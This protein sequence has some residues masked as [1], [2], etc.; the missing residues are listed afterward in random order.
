MSVG[1]GNEPRACKWATSPERERVGRRGT[2]RLGKTGPPSGSVRDGAPVANGPA[3]LRSGFVTL[4]V[5]CVGYHD[6]DVSA[7]AYLITFHTYGTWLHGHERGSVDDEHNVPGTPCLPPDAA[8]ETRDFARLKHAP[9]EL[10]AGR[11]FVVDATVREVCAYRSWRLHA[12][13][14]RSTHVHAVVSAAHAP[15]RVMNDLK[16]YATRRMREAAVLPA[17]VEPWSYHGS[18]RYLNTEAPLARAVEYVLHEQGAALEMVCPV[19]WRPR[20][21]PATRREP[22]A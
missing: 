10:D 1:D 22:R 16:A 11:R 7:L 3:R 8:R 19:G 9:V 17:A 14:V 13:N 5:R 4:G 6:V 20:E 2:G 12:L 18:T 21:H 15:E